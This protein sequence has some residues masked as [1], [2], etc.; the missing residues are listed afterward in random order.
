MTVTSTI[1]AFKAALLAALQQRTGLHGVEVSWGYPFNSQSREWLF[2]GNVSGDQ[3]AA[4]L[5]RQRR[6]ESYDLEVII[7]VLKPG[8]R[9]D[10]RARTERAF[11]IAAEV[12]DQLRTD[13]SVGQVVRVAQVEGPLRLSEF[14]VGDSG[15]EVGAELLLTIHVDNRI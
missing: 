12:E 14:F 10:I 5:G 7:A 6:E 15:T 9:G 13:A 11:E 8:S 2:L 1:P 4:A 3:T